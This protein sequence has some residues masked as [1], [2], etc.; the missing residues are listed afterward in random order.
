MQYMAYA[1]FIAGYLF[2]LDVN[3]SLMLVAWPLVVLYTAA[4]PGV[5][6]RLT[7]E[8]GGWSV[9]NVWNAAGSSCEMQEAGTRGETGTGAARGASR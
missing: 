3:W 8:T 6:G 1:P 2:G 4:A 5:P 9:Q 7:P